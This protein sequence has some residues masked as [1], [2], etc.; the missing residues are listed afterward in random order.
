[1]KKSNNTYLSLILLWVV[2]CLAVSSVQGQSDMLKLIEKAQKIAKADSVWFIKDLI[3]DLPGAAPKDNKVPM[4]KHSLILQKGTEYRIYLF[5]AIE[6][7]ESHPRLEL[8]GNSELIGSVE[9]IKDYNY[10]DI[11]S[12][13][14][15]VYHFFISDVN[16]KKAQGVAAICLKKN[17][18]KV[19]GTAFGE[20]ILTFV[21]QMPQ[22]PGGTAALNRFIGK[23][24]KYPE[25]AKKQGISGRVILNFV[26]GKTG[27][28]YD[29]RVVKGLSTSLDNEAIR[30][31]RSMPD[32]IPGKHKGVPVNV[33]FTLPVSCKTD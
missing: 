2:A 23:N 21:D 10:V 13:R 17:N 5:D 9:C 29:I 25:D 6:N 28:I 24:L 7:N 15:G 26:V 18:Q 19:E 31:V 11:T 27:K 16:R 12:K 1:M 33:Y 30:M 3:Y 14:S 22:F 20:E 4:T 32:W 8:Y